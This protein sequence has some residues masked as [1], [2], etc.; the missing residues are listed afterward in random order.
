M[1]NEKVD[2]HIRIGDKVYEPILGT[3]CIRD[4][5]VTKIVISKK[6]ISL[7]L[8]YIYTDTVYKCFPDNEV[9]LDCMVS[10]NLF[11][12]EEEA[13]QKL[14]ELYQGRNLDVI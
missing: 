6:G 12:S 2:F 14:I 10:R 7:V 3:P 9:P 5:E 4:L 1:V 13:K 11:F 8:N